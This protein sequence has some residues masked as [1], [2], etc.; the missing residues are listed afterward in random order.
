MTTKISIATVSYLRRWQRQHRRLV[1]STPRRRHLFMARTLALTGMSPRQTAIVTAHQARVDAT[2]CCDA[3]AE[4]VAAE[5]RP[6]LFAT[7]V[8]E[9]LAEGKTPS[10]KRKP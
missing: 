10:R 7:V 8:L 2:F 4:H 1:G 6:A 9:S 3:V 5:L